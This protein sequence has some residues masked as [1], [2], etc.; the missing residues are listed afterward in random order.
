MWR[1]LAAS[2]RLARP[3][4]VDLVIALV[5]AAATSPRRRMA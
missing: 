3:E 5:Q 1:S 2:N 4:A